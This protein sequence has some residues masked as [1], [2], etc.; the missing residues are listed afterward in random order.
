MFRSK[1]GDSDEDSDPDSETFEPKKSNKKSKVAKIHSE[2]E[3]IEEKPEKKKRDR[4]DVWIEWISFNIESK[5]NIITRRLVK[6]S[7]FERQL[8]LAMELSKKEGQATASTVETL[9]TA[10]PSTSN[11]QESDLPVLFI[12][13][14]VDKEK[15]VED[16]PK[17]VTAEQIVDLI[18]P[19][20]TGDDTVKEVEKAVETSAK[21]SVKNPKKKLKIVSDDES[22]SCSEAAFKVDDQEGDEEF[23]MASEKAKEKTKK[24]TPSKEKAATK[25]KKTTPK[26]K[27]ESA[28]SKASKKILTNKENCES[29]SKFPSE[30]VEAVI[31]IAEAPIVQE[32]IKDTSMQLEPEVPKPKKNDFVTAATVKSSNNSTS[33]KPVA[34]N[35]FNSSLSAASSSA[36]PLGRI[37]IKNSSPYVRVGLSRN[38]KIKPLHPNLK[39]I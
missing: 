19:E 17:D 9:A 37:E 22:D 10:E 15:P 29:A 36:S 8:R 20:K 33:A 13:H 4:L 1:H 27:K 3:S 16:I 23:E 14:N 35:K 39:P 11:E 34:S 32:K 7:T 6:E 28:K 5:L 12:S 18:S 30:H 26:E 25:E 31:K 2:D 38:S 21:K 24:K